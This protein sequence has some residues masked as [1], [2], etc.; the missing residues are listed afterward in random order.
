MFQLHYI[1]QGQV[2][3]YHQVGAGAGR[4]SREKGESQG[5]LSLPARWT[6]CFQVQRQYASECQLLTSNCTR[7]L[8]LLMGCLKTTVWLREML[9]SIT[10]FVHHEEDLDTKSGA[11]C[12]SSD[13]S[14]LQQEIYGRD[15]FTII[16]ILFRPDQIWEEL[17]L[18]F[19]VCDF[20]VVCKDVNALFG[21]G[22][23]DWGWIY[24]GQVQRSKHLGNIGKLEWIWQGSSKLNVECPSVKIKTI[25][26]IVIIQGSHLPHSP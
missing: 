12:S 13:H 8:F 26:S 19:S 11:S 15:F 25:K 21:A 18:C 7:E 24:R 3:G 5:S 22:W 23:Q 1:C 9:K 2:A 20:P 14:W 16:L 17:L 4:S 6:W 10:L